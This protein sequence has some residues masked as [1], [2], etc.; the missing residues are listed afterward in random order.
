MRHFA[1][2]TW[3]FLF[4]DPVF[5][6]DIEQLQ[7]R[8]KNCCECLNKSVCTLLVSMLDVEEKL[9]SRLG[10]RASCFYGLCTLCFDKQKK[11]GSNER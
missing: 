8:Y 11:C 4:E 5:I 2:F 7:K 10:A 9:L 1:E 3:E 6:V